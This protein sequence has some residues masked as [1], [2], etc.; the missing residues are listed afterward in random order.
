M[1]AKL[2]ELN[3][4]DRVAFVEVCG[5]LYEHSPWI[6]E[7]AWTHRPFETLAALH[8]A[9]RRVLA[10]ATS[11]EQLALICA[12]PDLVG[13]AALAGQLTSASTR[14]QAAAGLTALSSDEIE[15]F[16]TYNGEYHRRFG[17][18]FVICAR[19]NKKAAIL[20]AL[21][22]RLLNDREQEIRTALAEIDKIAWLR[23]CDAIEETS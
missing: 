22:K 6:A 5:P 1:T 2:A 8:G 7:R 16:R 18:P 10:E 17:F 9:F 12:H 15:A 23:L 4:A 19:E 13:R 20:A 3:R 21:P 11:E 14:E